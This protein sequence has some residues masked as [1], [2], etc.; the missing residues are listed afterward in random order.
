MSL[1]FVFGPSGVGKSR[2]L[3][4]E[5]LRDAAR[6]RKK[7]F[8][9]IVPDQFTMQ[10]Q[11]ELAALSPAGGIM[12]IDI[13]SFSR[14]NHR[15]LEEVGRPDVPVLDD[16]GKSLVLQKVAAG[17]KDDLPVLGS[18]LHRQG[19][20][21]EV[22]SAISEFMQYGISPE[23]VTELINYS[24]GS[25]ALSR[26]LSDLQRLYF[27]FRDYIRDHY[28]TTEETLDVLTRSL[29]KSELLRNSVVVFDG[30]TG[31]T[32]IQYNCIGELMRL[33]EEVILT[34]TLGEGENPYLP[35][36]EQYLF[37]LSKKT[38]G[39]LCRLAGEVKCE[40]GQDVFLV[41]GTKEKKSS[42]LMELQGR[43]QVITNT[44]HRFEEAP[45]LLHLEQNLF[46]FSGK[47]TCGEQ[48]E[49]SAFA[50]SS[51]K[52]EVHQVGLKIHELTR[53]EKVPYREIALIL[54]DLESYAPYVEREFTGLG[55]PFYLDRTRQ[56]ALNPL[57]EFMKSALKLF[58]LDFSYEAVVHFL[59]SGLCGMEREEIDLFENYLLA[60][61]VR[62][63][64]R[65]QKPFTSMRSLAKGDSESLSR[66]NEIRERLVEQLSCLK[67][68][69]EL[70]AADCVNHLYDFLEQNQ[71]EEKLA[72]WQAF[73]EKEGDMVRAK[74]YAQIYRLVC[75][76]LEQIYLLLGEEKLSWKEFG[77][78]LEAGIGE[79]E[80]G[81]IPLNVD[82]VIVGDIERT[83][84][85]QVKY[86]F[87]LGV[88]A[89]NI[90]RKSAKGGILS[91]MDREFLQGSALELAPSPRQ[92]MFIQRFY[93]YLNL[94]KPSKGLCLSYARMDVAGKSIRPSYLCETIS[95][96]FP[97][98]EVLCPE[99][100][101]PLEQIVTCPEGEEY[102]A[103]GLREY[104]AGTLTGEKEQELAAIYRAFEGSGME[105]RR[106][107]LLENAFGRYQSSKLSQVVARALY[108]RIFSNSISR[109]E[110]FAACAYR[111]FL[112]YGL[113]LTER[114]G[115]SFEAVDAGNLYHEVLQKFGEQLE[116]NGLTWMN[117]TEEF[118]KRTVKKALEDSAGVYGDQILYSSA[119]NSFALTGMER[120]LTRTVCALQEQLR[121]G[122]FEPVNYELGFGWA[123]RLDSLNLSLSPTERMQ[124]QGRI[125][126]IDV[127]E[128]ESAVYVKVVDYK[129][130]DKQFDLAAVYHGLSLQ[131]VVYMNAA[132]ELE[133]K[134][135]PDKDILPAALLY[136]HVNDPLVEA[137]GE[138][139]DEELNQA[140]L[141][142]LRMKGIVS[143]EP[144]VAERL[145][146][147]FETRS[148]VIPVER[149]KNGTF[150][151][152]SSV[153][154]GEELQTVSRYVT[155]KIKSIG[156]KILDG[157]IDLE[158]Y[159][160]A[161]EN[162]C[163]WCSFRKVCGFD[164]ARPGCERRTLEELSKEEALELMKNG[165]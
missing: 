118:A 36:G 102:L 130:G 113:A 71:A 104:A 90:P 63:W 159:E 54:G 15:I 150:S 96:M 66:I 1:R 163:Q 44:R 31:F 49:V 56:I 131:L 110:T 88:N 123:D 19:Y 95:G 155:A 79:I 5:I 114:E 47:A 27:G 162:A 134:K 81:T 34:V 106:K 111:Y 121:R 30:F 164:P 21:H 3:Y 160:M 72:A 43:C 156:R 8:L 136:Y 57:V 25:Q 138:L 112:Q 69:E 135:H 116:E 42:W 133:A 9:I 20:I 24:A 6:D 99:N 146:G 12:N 124:L 74:E 103:D 64:K 53:M 109:L 132:L 14:L 92:Q 16:T 46:R 4:E 89:G 154:S 101:S 68:G 7:N 37:H 76:L 59:R 142:S 98:M 157:N 73:F 50:A 97:G 129:S 151:A 83:R 137:G 141:K 139:S 107:V 165:C 67:P 94:T 18:F 122:S 161:K 149:N 86:L 140:I 45:S 77:E 119:R 61:G 75:E 35:D 128:E 55:I 85:K 39:D 84:L 26:K 91:D 127:R 78:I 10:T 62:G 52:E 80:V 147:E 125:D 120:I 40:R 60:T 143:S 126:R 51:P 11:K 38:I 58:V 2:W 153:L 22:K 65:Y 13:L 29:E 87:F 93:L 145:D 48:R 152:R 117:F 70:T 108:G 158:P 32:P 82:R 115:F 28:I 100:R 105:D 33:C 17:M 41:T 144:G 23:D 148:D